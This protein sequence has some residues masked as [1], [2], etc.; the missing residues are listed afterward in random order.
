MKS[1]AI[2]VGFLCIFVLYFSCIDENFEIDE[3]KG[4][5]DTGYVTPIWEVWHGGDVYSID[6]YGR[7]FLSSGSNRCV[8]IWYWYTGNP[9][10]QHTIGDEIPSDPSNAVLFYEYGCYKGLFASGD[11][12]LQKWSLYPYFY[13][14][15]EGIVSYEWWQHF[16]NEQHTEWIWEIVD[17]NTVHTVCINPSDYSCCLAAFR[18][19]LVCLDL[20]HTLN[21][22]GTFYRNMNYINNGESHNNKSIWAIDF[23]PGG[24]YFLTGGFDGNVCYWYKLDDAC[25][26]KLGN[27]SSRHKD[28]V[29]C[30]RFNPSNS[31]RA[32]SCSNDRKIKYWDVDN[33]I[34]LTTL[35][36]YH[37]D[38]VSSIDIIEHNSQVYMLS[39][40]DDG[41]MIYWKI[42]NDDSISPRYDFYTF[43]KHINSVSFFVADNH[44]C[45]LSA[46][47]DGTIKCYDLSGL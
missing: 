21:E 8:S 47:F 24:N 18:D 3:K 30:V 20:N 13:P 39:G 14:N 41:H 16:L 31:T 4:I 6:S 15:R 28:Y 42:N 26:Y 29:R 2:I 12:Y 34:C 44:F 33:N 45:A 1:K 27:T 46:G 37:S 17:T 36:N 38:C 22:D 19:S 5:P 43:Q 10:L 35:E 40:S 11:G 9:S 32:A 23:R 7:C 25:K